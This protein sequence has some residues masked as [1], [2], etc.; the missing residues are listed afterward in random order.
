[1]VLDFAG[2]QPTRRP[3]WVELPDDL[4]SAVVDAL[5]VRED[6]DPSDLS[7]LA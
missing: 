5:P 6:C 2:V 1:M 4:F 3:R 7:V